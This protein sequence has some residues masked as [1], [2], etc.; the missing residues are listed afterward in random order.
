MDEIIG[1]YATI[2]PK[3]L[4]AHVSL[5]LHSQLF[6]IRWSYC[7]ETAEL[8]SSYLGNLLHPDGSPVPD[9]RGIGFVLNELVENAFKYRQSGAIVV[10]AGLLDEE[11]VLSVSN[12]IDAAKVS[13]LRVIFDE[14]LSRDPRD[15]FVQRVEASAENPDESASGLGFITMM[16]EHDV[17][18]GWRMCSQAEFGPDQ[19]EL[20]S[21]AWLPL[22]RLS[23]LPG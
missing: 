23:L 3:E 14:L 12:E 6:P 22:R 13:K 16:I 7:A 18:L 9:V 5:T 4:K 10:Q 2:D 15:L 21:T 8:V 11:I 20:T 1:H 17:R 19:V